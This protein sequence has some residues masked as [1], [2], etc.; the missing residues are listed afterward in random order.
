MDTN[1]RRTRQGKPVTRIAVAGGVAGLGLAL[2]GI[3]IATADDGATGSPS[4][5]A[6]GIQ[7]DPGRGF[8]HDGPFGDELATRLAEALGVEQAEVAAALE[9][10]RGEL[11]PERPEWG[12]GGMP[13]PPTEEELDARKSV[14]AAGLADALGLEQDDVEAALTE[15]RTD[16]E[17]EAEDRLGDLRAEL[18]PS[19]VER[20]DEAVADG[21][22]SEADKTSVLKA[23]DAGVI[24]GLGAGGPFG[25]GLFGGRGWFGGS[26]ESSSTAS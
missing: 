13:E 22:L 1:T 6:S 9:D 24:G 25:H 4:A 23:Y 2:G 12:E 14:L 11:V 3:A 19:L 20:L 18:R 26:T 10:L 7:Q 8:G 15:I 16:L 17:A 21:T 5:V